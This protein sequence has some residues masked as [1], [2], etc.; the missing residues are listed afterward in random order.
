[1]AGSAAELSVGQ[2]IGTVTLNRP[3]RM[4]C[5]D[6]DT[7]DALL[8][9]IRR[10]GSDPA[11]KV[12]VL[13]GSG[14]AFCAGGDVRAMHESSDPER[15]L[16][17][18]AQRIH[19]V[20]LALQRT[21]KV[22]LAAINGA[23]TGAGCSLA[24]AC[25]LKL[26]AEGAEF[27]MWFAGVGLA[28]GCG[29]Q[30]LVEHVGFARASELALTGHR[31][32]AAEALEAGLVNWVVPDSELDARA[33][34]KALELSG[35]ALVAVAQAKELLRQSRGGALERQLELER[36]FLSISGATED[37][38]EGT[39]AFVRKRKPAFMGR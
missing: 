34:E 28:P 12:I 25:D 3:E 7:C 22:V 2:G 31:L 10:A 13:R 21:P 1:M 4:N 14:K 19:A 5:L 8:G 36:H 17:E 35:N 38:R 29:T 23:A 33:R 32:C 16:M 27:G 18:L 6:L 9:C 15:F 20:V 30:L 26:A 24:M 11:V 37:F 39:E